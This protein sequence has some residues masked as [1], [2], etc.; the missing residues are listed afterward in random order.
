MIQAPHALSLCDALAALRSGELTSESYTRALLQRVAAT[1]ANVQ[2]WTHLDPELAL[3]AARD[4]DERRQ[5]GHEARALAGIGIGIKDIIAT[6]DQPT[7]MGSPIYAGARAPHDAEC[8][9]R[10]RRAGGFVFGKT[11]TTEFAFMQPGKTRNPWHAAHTPGGSSS[12]SAAAVAMGHV[13]TALG[14]QTNGSVIRPA[15]YCGVVGF[16]PTIDLLPF[17]GIHPFS[18]TLDTL[19]VFARSVGDCALVA[20]CLAHD[21]AISRS[22]MTLDHPPRL[23]YL[24]DFPW[25]TATTEQR[26]ALAAALAKLHADGT[27]VTPVVLPD[28]WHDA[29]LVL[30][31]IMFREA[32]QQLGE[33]QDR[34]RSRMSVKLNAAIDEGRATTDAHYHEALKRRDAMIALATEWLAAFDAIVTPP[35]PGAAPADLTQTGDPSF[36]TLWSLIGAPALTLPIGLTAN[37]LPLGLQLAALAG[38]DDGLL[39]V[40]QWCELRLP[41]QG[42][43]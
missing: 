11:V 35:A 15:A 10:L 26:A 34:E 30:R 24:A 43:L 23:A 32:F 20:N 14:T 25:S 38:D 6:A 39:A 9:A 3:G 42:L 27:T 33:L 4:I 31:A 36:C 1:D 19:G 41:F 16:K 7:Q 12:G 2:A 13:P 17:A 18:P 21:E 8:V 37:R 5:A 40:A 28:A 22:P 29:N